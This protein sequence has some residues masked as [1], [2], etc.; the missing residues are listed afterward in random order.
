MN[1]FSEWINKE[2]KLKEEEDMAKKKEKEIPI[3]TDAQLTLVNQVK[4]LVSEINDS[5]VEHITY[6]DI[7]KLDKA[8]DDVVEESNL[9]HQQHKVDYGEDKGSIIKAW[10]K[11]LV[12]A[13]NPNAWKGNDDD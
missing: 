3:I 5:G 1:T 6:S 10:Y 2:L 11:E 4:S 8:Y 7:T 13:D 9:K 12:R